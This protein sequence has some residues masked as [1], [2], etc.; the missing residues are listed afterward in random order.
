MVFFKRALAIV[1][2]TVAGKYVVALADEPAARESTPHSNPSD[3]AAVPK[4]AAVDAS[5]LQ[6]PAN[7]EQIARW[8]KDLDDSQ[9]LVRE[10][11]TQHLAD[12]GA[13][14]FDPLLSVANGERPEP[15]DR[16]TWI[17]QRYS[18]SRDSEL[19]FAALEHL[20]QLK[21]APSIATKADADLAERALAVCQKRL[22][23]LGADVTVTIGQESVQ[24]VVPMV[25]VRLGERWRGTPEDLRQLTKLK[26]QRFFRLDGAGVNDDVVKMFADKEKLSL[27]HLFNTSATPASVDAVKLKH[28]D[29]KLFVRNAAMLGVGGD[30]HASGVLVHEV[31]QGSGAANAGILQGDIITAL[32]GQ[33]I[34][35]FDRLTAR[36][37]QHQPGDKVEVAILRNEQAKTVT[38]VLG[39]RP[40]NEP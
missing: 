21:N 5:R 17:L 15:A 18:R 28:P 24:S 7:A 10:A 38:V 9:Y 39:K 34:P 22:T 8:L 12:A 36:I 37:A 13:A 29:A 2:L 14:A 40:D 33:K 6:P 23:A 1:W 26:Q 3:Q 32:D 31:P 20:A 35:D 4:S 27:L 11:A 25:L 16:A 30:T 19:A